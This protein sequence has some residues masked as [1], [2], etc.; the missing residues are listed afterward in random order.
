MIYE[1]FVSYCASKEDSFCFGSAIVECDSYI[2]G[3]ERIKSMERKISG[4]IGCEINVMNFV[5]LD[6]NTTEFPQIAPM[7][8]SATSDKPTEVI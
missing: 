2:K 5:L 8:N 1:Y 7:G 4:E 3:I 6:V